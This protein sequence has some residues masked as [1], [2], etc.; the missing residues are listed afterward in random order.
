MIKIAVPVKGRQFLR[1]KTRFPETALAI[2]EGLQYNIVE[3]FSKLANFSQLY[4][5]A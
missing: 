2:E 1:K 5:K 4:K 3:S